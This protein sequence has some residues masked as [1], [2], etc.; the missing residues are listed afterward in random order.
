[1]TLRRLGFAVAVVLLAVAALWSARREITHALLVERARALGLS[2]FSVDVTSL[3]FGHATL[4]N[5]RV[6]ARS[7]APSLEISGIELSYSP[8]SL[9]RQRLYRVDVD[10][11]HLRADLRDDLFGSTFSQ[12]SDGSLAEFHPFD[13]L[14]VGSAQ[15]TLQSENNGKIR[16]SGDLHSRLEK[17][18]A[19][20]FDLAF[21]LRV[22]R[23]E[24][25]LRT[26]VE[27]KFT[28]DSLL[29]MTLAPFGV[30]GRIGESRDAMAFE[31]KTPIVEVRLDASD[32]DAPLRLQVSA[33]GGRL[34][35]P[36][37]FIS[38]E[39]LGFFLDIDAE[40]RLPTSVFAL[41]RIVDWAT[42][43]R[44]G[45]LKAHGRVVPESDGRLR[46]DL[47]LGDVDGLMR[48]RLDGWHEM[49]TGDGSL[50][51]AL[52][53]STLDEIGARL[54]DLFPALNGVV[55]NLTGQLELEGVSHWKAD[56]LDL[57][58]TIHLRDLGMTT[59]LGEL[60]GVNASISLVGPTPFY[61]PEVQRVTV[62]RFSAGVDL[63]NAIIDFRLR[64]DGTVE[65]PRLQ[66]D[67][68][69]GI[70]RTRG[71]Y[72]PQSTQQAFTVEAVDVDLRA[73]IELIDLDGLSG[74][75]TLD[76]VFPI[77][78]DDGV[79]ELRGATLTSDPKGGWLRYRPTGAA[80][81]VTASNEHLNQLAEI[82]ENFNFESIVISL[83]GNVL[84]GVQVAIQL[85]GANPDYHDGFPI[86]LN[87]KIE[88]QFG[89]LIRSGTAAFRFATQ[90]TQALEKSL[91]RGG[92]KTAE[93]R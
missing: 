81:A 71:V 49:A 72:D 78:I 39:E 51:F 35:F 37:E 6:D 10:V 82:L 16:L 74:E 76:G 12:D 89:D 83:N 30:N 38:F 1:M 40:E 4:A 73:L 62:E 44:F 65:I 58:F 13:S 69:E 43:R 56:A 55:S 29:E 68:A 80:S 34:N 86:E 52:E 66:W 7:P 48:M 47:H 23:P 17:D 25:V 85:K 79:I 5:L 53:P 50:A 33:E 8:D 3:N 28:R 45:P 67:F 64:R 87:T 70:A 92:H 91:R 18:A 26:Q 36:T 9:L 63:L 59:D 77:Y 54:P 41:G 11:L 19:I 61:M 88:S 31:F 32:T 27:G 2:E 60:S 84:G 46:I 14:N 24:V 90:A 20:E 15:L 57:E 93:T 42:P 22:E 75:G 21:E